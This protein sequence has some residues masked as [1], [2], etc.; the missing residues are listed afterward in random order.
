ML[1]VESLIWIPIH[2]HQPQVTAPLS[3]YSDT[4]MITDENSNT[5]TIPSRT[6][7]PGLQDADILPSQRPMLHLV[8]TCPGSRASAL[9]TNIFSPS[10]RCSSTPQR[11]CHIQYRGIIGSQAHRRKGCTQKQRGQLTSELIRW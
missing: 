1:E 6:G 8:W 11:F 2:S 4:S 9:D 10:P 5:A 7:N 3:R